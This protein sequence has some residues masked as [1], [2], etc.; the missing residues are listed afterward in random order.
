MSVPLDPAWLDFIDIVSGRTDGT[1][2]FRG[3][4]DRAWTLVPS[5]GRAHV[6]GAAPYRL[7]DEEDLFKAYK[8][9]VQRFETSLHSDL[10]WLALGQHHG[11]PTRLLDWTQNPLVAAWFA[12]ESEALNGADGQIHMVQISANDVVDEV[13][14]VFATAPDTLFVRVPP[15]TARITAQQGLFSLHSDPTAS[16]MA[17]GT[18]IFHDTFDVP[19]RAKPYFREALHRFGFDRGRLMTDLDGLCATLSWTYRTRI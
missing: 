3:H 14:D 6:L 5:V 8:R 16:W 4:A 15:R 17:S 19:L 2:V 13:V 12:V 10:E 7:K 18:T 9:E 11:L 1:W